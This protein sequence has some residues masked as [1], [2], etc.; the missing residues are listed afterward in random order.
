MDCVE[1]TIETSRNWRRVGLSGALDKVL[2]EGGGIFTAEDGNIG[3]FAGLF[4]GVSDG[5]GV[6][7]ATGKGSKSKRVVLSGNPISGAQGS[8]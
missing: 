1:R 6:E 7:L 5:R 8:G 4:R 2:A 3:S